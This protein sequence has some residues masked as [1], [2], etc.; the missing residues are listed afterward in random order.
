MFEDKDTCMLLNDHK[1]WAALNSN[2]STTLSFLQMIVQRSLAAKN[3][4]HAKGGSILTG[5]FKLL[6]LVLLIF[7]G[8][9]SRVLYPGIV[10]YNYFSCFTWVLIYFWIPWFEFSLC[11]WVDDVACTDPTICEAV[12][13]NPV[14]CSNIAY[15]KLVLELLPYGRLTF[16]I[17]FQLIV[18]WNNFQSRIYM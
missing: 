17:K 13:D 6:P 15:P 7:P 2:W 3:L 9:I 8:M 16:T 18:D 4:S 11:V 5:Y 14:G 1:Y 12:C 10:V